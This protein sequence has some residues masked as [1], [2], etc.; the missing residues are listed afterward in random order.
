MHTLTADEHTA[1]IKSCGN[2]Y[3]PKEMVEKKKKKLTVKQI[4]FLKGKRAKKMA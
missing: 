3:L 1:L 4:F 2:S